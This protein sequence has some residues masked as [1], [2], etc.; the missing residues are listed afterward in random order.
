MIFLDNA[1]TTKM[2]SELNSIIEHYNCIDYYNPSALYAQS[3][4]VARD[5]KEATNIIKASLGGMPESKVIICSSATEANNTVLLGQ[6]NKRFKKILISK[7]EHNSVYNF[8]PLLSKLGF[9]VE[10]LNLDCDGVV[11][12]NEL[13]SKMT[14]DVGLVSVIHSSNETGAIN[15]IKSLVKVAKSINPNCL[16]HSDGVQAFGKIE[17]NVEDLGV[18]FYTLTSHKICGPKGVAA[19]YSKKSIKPLLYGGDQQ[20]GMRSSTENVSGIMA[21]AHLCKNLDI[22]SKFEKVK[23]LNNLFRNIIAESGEKN[24][25]INSRECNNPYVIS[26]SCLGV[27]GETMVHKL[28]SEGVLVSTGSACS[29]TK[30]GNRVLDTMG[31]GKE[32][33]L[34]SIR[35]SFGPDN[36]CEEVEKATKLIVSC[37]KDLTKKLKGI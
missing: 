29:S 25:V 37:Y 10:Y 5:I 11:T 27:M 9:E 32:Y 12:E 28:E 1:S 24:L 16:F 13:R 7:G 36:T 3:L 15:D 17:V 26:L 18:D 34:G 31:L 6:L 21:F 22:Q 19:L 30:V 8:N 2:S 4:S 20:E 33:Q 14:K 35:I 23:K